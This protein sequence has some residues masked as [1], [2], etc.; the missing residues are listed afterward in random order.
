VIGSAINFVLWAL[1][2][3]VILFFGL[4][5]TQMGDCPENVI[6][7][8]FGSACTT[9]KHFWGWGLLIVGAAAWMTGIHF[10]F[11]RRDAD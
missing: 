2:V 9:Q 7:P 1:I 8:S 11:R 5:M 10:I 6:D 4:F 3:F